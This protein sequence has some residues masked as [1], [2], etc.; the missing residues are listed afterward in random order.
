MVFTSRWGVVLH[1]RSTALLNVRW[2]VTVQIIELIIPNGT[3]P[4]PNLGV[5]VGLSLILLVVIVE[6]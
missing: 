2:R 4:H 5:Y 1:W 6:I 3:V